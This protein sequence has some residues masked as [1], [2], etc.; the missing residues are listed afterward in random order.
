MGCDASE[1]LTRYREGAFVPDRTRGQT[2]PEAIGV[3]DVYEDGSIQTTQGCQMVE[4][5]IWLDE[6]K[7]RAAAYYGWRLAGVETGRDM[8]T[9]RTLYPIKR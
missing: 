5:C 1:W 9:G 4:G 6:R 3:G 7:A 8:R 2:A